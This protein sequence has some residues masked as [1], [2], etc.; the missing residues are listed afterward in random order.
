MKHQKIQNILIVGGG[1]AG[2]MTAAYL[3]QTFNA[4]EPTMNIS[5]IEAANENGDNSAPQAVGCLPFLRGF[6]NYL[7]IHEQT[8]MGAC[9]ASFKMATLFE[10]WKDGSEAD[11]YWHTLG[12]VANHQAERLALTEHWLHKHHQGEETSFA[13]S[14][15]EAVAVCKAMKTPKVA[16][17]EGR[18][19]ALPYAHHLD[20]QLMVQLL[21]KYATNRGVNHLVGD[22][23]AIDVD[24]SG[25]IRQVQTE[26]HGALTA[27]LYVDCTGETSMLLGQTLQEKED[28]YSN[29]LRCDAKVSI[30]LPYGEN[31]RYNQSAGGLKPYTTATALSAG[32][33]AHIPIQIC[34]TYTYTYSSQFASKEAAEMEL[35]QHIGDRS[36]Q[37]TALHQN[38]QQG[39]KQNLWVKNCVAIGASGGQIEALEATDLALI[40]L[41]LRYLLYSFP[42]QTMDS[43]LQDTYNKAMNQL[44]ANVQDFVVLHYCLTQRADTPFWKAVKQET[45]I[46][47]VLQQKLEEWKHFLPDGF[48]HKYDLFGS[49]NY[50][51]VL[52]GM[53][54]LPSKA[55]PIL[56]HSL[57]RE[58]EN[59]FKQVAHQSE[60]MAKK[61]PTQAEYFQQLIR[62]A[63]FQ[64]NKAW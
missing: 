15:Q 55:L 34:E 20:V 33:L 27:D 50:V 23:A 26:E 25:A 19:R 63:N 47:S 3:N 16:I 43:R 35:R 13:E 22:V 14:L 24:E 51:S 6:F 54:Y 17:S 2:W 1:T 39:K 48:D 60:Q 41:A 49:F 11:S 5:L 32:W 37:E 64:K 45:E 10:G 4:T 53:D 59:F 52:A 58:A 31:N 61:L 57:H 44:Y 40:Q 7:G 28:S 30:T 8:W 38:L 18:S 9:H 62:I 46:P 56:Q 36:E 29:H 21:K 42:D 12:N